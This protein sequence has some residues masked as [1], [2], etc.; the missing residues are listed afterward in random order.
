MCITLKNGY[1]ITGFCLGQYVDLSRK[2]PIQS[3]SVARTVLCLSNS[4]ES[5][6]QFQQEIEHQRYRISKYLEDREFIGNRDIMA[7]N[8]EVKIS[9]SD[10][11]RVLMA[12]APDLKCFDN[13]GF[14]PCYFLPFY[15]DGKPS[16]FG[17][18]LN[19]IHSRSSNGENIFGLDK[20]GVRKILTESEMKLLELIEKSMEFPVQLSFPFIREL[21]I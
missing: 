17:I 20:E 10:N 15:K 21:N 9:T 8:P 13:T 3:T 5:Q 1:G 11:G 2:D 7:N 12:E 14:V 18:K 6:R 4:D 19:L 16:F